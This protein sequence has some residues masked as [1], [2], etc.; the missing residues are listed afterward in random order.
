MRAE[1]AFDYTDFQKSLDTLVLALDK[2]AGAILRQQAGLLAKALAAATPPFKGRAE[3]VNAVSRDLRQVF[4]TWREMFKSIEKRDPPLAAAYWRAV[5]QGRKAEA[6]KIARQVLGDRVIEVPDRAI[7]RQRRDSYGR[8]SGK[9][10]S[11]YVTNEA[12]LKRYLRQREQHVGMTKAPWAKIA[13][14]YGVRMPGWTTRAD[15]PVTVSDHS[16]APAIREKYIVIASALPWASHLRG[17]Q[18]YYQNAMQVRADLMTVAAAKALE[19][20]RRDM[21]RSGYALGKM[22]R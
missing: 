8:V 13:T 16:N 9:Y 5:K 10:P 12:S 4:G 17:W 19:Q 18:T 2:D 6:V 3:G 7:H 15:V 14:H 1:F 20:R 22:L 21:L 11:A